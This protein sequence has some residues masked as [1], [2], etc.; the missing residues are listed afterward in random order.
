MRVYCFIIE[1]AVLFSVEIRGTIESD[2]LVNSSPPATV[3]TD[4]INNASYFS[5][6][7]IKDISISNPFFNI[8]TTKMEP[9]TTKTEPL[10]SKTEPPT[11][12]T[13]PPTTITKHSTGKT[14]APAIKTE[15]PTIKTEPPSTETEPPTIKTEPPTTRTEL[16]TTVTKQSTG[17]TEKPTTKTKSPIIKTEPPT[18]KS[19]TPT[20]YTKPS[21]TRT[22]PPTTTTEQPTMRTTSPTT[23]T[24]H[25]TTRANPPTSIT[26]QSTAKTEAPATDPSKCADTPKL[27]QMFVHIFN[28][29]IKMV[30]AAMD[31]LET[32][33][34]IA[35]NIGNAKFISKIVQ[36]FA[37]IIQKLEKRVVN[38]LISSLRYFQSS[39]IQELETKDDSISCEQTIKVVNCLVPHL[40]EIETLINKRIK[41]FEYIDLFI[42][43]G[44]KQASICNQKILFKGIS[45]VP[46][47]IKYVKNQY[48]IILSQIASINNVEFLSV[49]HR[50]RRHCYRL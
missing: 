7:E 29:Y 15:P 10:I 25:L 43:Q 30:N 22:E 35:S 16:P 39:I 32:D 50:A 20:T 17:K 11:T 46:T 26:K 13:E 3:P 5:P 49:A 23:T 40:E 2:S 48:S 42:V 18:T 19:E 31:R 37:K 38:K 8:P 41:L 47:V 28:D 14:E 33:T 4:S 36:R 34:S 27:T 21:F 12:G 9:P 44:T 1:F 45:C 24:E 6:T